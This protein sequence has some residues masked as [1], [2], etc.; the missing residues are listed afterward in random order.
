MMT[1]NFENLRHLAS[2]DVGEVQLGMAR[3]W[4]HW[5]NEILEGGDP[6]SI[7]NPASLNELGLILRPELA[8]L[9]EKKV[10]IEEQAQSSWDQYMV[11]VGV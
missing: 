11:H 8:V 1:N 5:T 7:P 4:D 2:L 3:P 9:A 6:S 10:W